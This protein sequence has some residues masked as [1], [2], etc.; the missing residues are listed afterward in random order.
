MN[1][2]KIAIIGGGNLGSAIAEGLIKS[3]FA[4]PEDIT[5]TRRNLSRLQSLKECSQSN[6]ICNI[7]IFTSTTPVLLQFCALRIICF[8]LNEIVAIL[9]FLLYYYQRYKCFL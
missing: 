2:K 6:R 9:F 5:I 3:A 1:S 8:L 7:L 4:K